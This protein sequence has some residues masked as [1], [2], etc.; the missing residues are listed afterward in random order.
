MY[1][2]PTQKQDIDVFSAGATINLYINKSISTEYKCTVGY[3]ENKWFR[4]K[5]LPIGMSRPNK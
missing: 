5:L 2:F 4:S 1:V 3:L